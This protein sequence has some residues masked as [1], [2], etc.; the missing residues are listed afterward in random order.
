M[1]YQS[2]LNIMLDEDYGDITDPT[3][4][5]DVKV[6]CSKTPGRMWA[7]TEVR[8]R[9]KQSALSSDSAQMKE[10]LSSIPDLDEL[11]ECKSYDELEKV[12]NDWLNSDSDDDSETERGSNFQSKTTKS[13]SSDNKSTS[14]DS[15]GSKSSKYKSLDDAFA[16]LEDL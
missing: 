15:S 6:V 11:Y 4:G 3:D 1:V 16:D 8:P 9:G 13:T 10:W 14:S 5:R 2:L 12:V 7:T